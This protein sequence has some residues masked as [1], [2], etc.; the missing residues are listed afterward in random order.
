MLSGDGI[1]P[2]LEPPLQ[3][4]F[5]QHLTGAHSVGEKQPSLE[6]SVS[7]AAGA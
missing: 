3:P 1:Q 5:A 6:G 7:P 2:P 4:D